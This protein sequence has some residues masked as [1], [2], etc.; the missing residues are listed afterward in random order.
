MHGHTIPVLRVKQCKIYRMYVGEKTHPIN[1][2]SAI[3]MTAISF[4]GKVLKF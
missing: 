3:K 2:R 4:K 1:Y